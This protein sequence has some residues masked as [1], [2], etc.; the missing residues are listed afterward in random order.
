MH[1]GAQKTPIQKTC[2]KGIGSDSINID[3]L[4]TN[5]QFDWLEIYLVYNKTA[6]KSC[7]VAPLTDYINNPIY[8]ELNLC[9][10][11]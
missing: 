2:E 11:C 6:C 5:R 8:Q 1:I 10:K 4:G 3:F 9:L 7:S